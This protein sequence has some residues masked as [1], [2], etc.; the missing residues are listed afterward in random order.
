MDGSSLTGLVERG[1][2][3]DERSAY[4]V[5]ASGRPSST[6]DARALS[7]Q[8]GAAGIF[9]LSWSLA[10]A[11]LPGVAADLPVEGPPLTIDH[12]QVDPVWGWYLSYPFNMLGHL[13]SASVPC[14]QTASGIPNG[15]QVVG[16][17]YDEASVLR[18]SAALERVRPAGRPVIV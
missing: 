10:S 7:V 14:G 1:P 17:P 5:Q 3:H 13:P 4:N 6:I 9:H 12:R 18:A 8:V 2:T 15:V 11:A 16:R